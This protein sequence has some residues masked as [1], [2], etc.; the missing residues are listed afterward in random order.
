MLLLLLLVDALA[1][2]CGCAGA[3]FFAVEFDV[4]VVV[5]TNELDDEI[6]TG[7]NLCITQTGTKFSLGHGGR[8]AFICS[9]QCCATP[10]MCASRK[11]RAISSFRSDEVRAEN[12]LIKYRRYDFATYS[13]RLLDTTLVGEL[14]DD[15]AGNSSSGCLK[16]HNDG[17][18]SEELDA[19]V[20]R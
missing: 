16:E 13:S 6:G 17:A 1:A 11:C 3:V 18:R 12:R 15:Q 4:A 7:C 10:C 2:S 14:D 20:R 19:V 5:V 8:S 9:T